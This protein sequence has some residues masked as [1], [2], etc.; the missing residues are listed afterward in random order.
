MREEETRPGLAE[1]VIEL[2]D[3]G[4][5]LTTDIVNFFDARAAK[6]IGEAITQI[7]P[8]HIFP[9]DCDP[10]APTEIE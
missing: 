4:T 3:H 9:A 5:G 2:A 10:G 7:R 8:P 6:P 1:D